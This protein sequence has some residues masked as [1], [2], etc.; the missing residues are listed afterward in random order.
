MTVV[1]ENASLD[2][3][4]ECTPETVQHLI[5]WLNSFLEKIPRKYRKTATIEFNSEME[6]DMP[7]TQ[8]C[9]SY[10]RSE[11]TEEYAIRYKRY[12]DAL[13]EQA[14]HDSGKKSTYYPHWDYKGKLHNHNPDMK[15]KKCDNCD[16]EG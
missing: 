10:Y 11:T 12:E 16:W 4:D 9:I 6:Y 15:D 3:D 5:E 14:E 13:K 2:D 8:L 1:F 7:C